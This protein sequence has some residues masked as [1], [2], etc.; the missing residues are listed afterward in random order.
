[1]RMRKRAGS[2]RFCI[3]AERLRLVPYSDTQLKKAQLQHPIS[4]T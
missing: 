4:H 1:M 2:K 3:Y